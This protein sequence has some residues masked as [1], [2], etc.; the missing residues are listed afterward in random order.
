[1]KSEFSSPLHDDWPS[2]AGQRFVVGNSELSF[3]RT[4]I[5]WDA[6]GPGRG[7]GERYR[8]LQSVHRGTNLPTPL[9]ITSLVVRHV[10][11]VTK[12]T[13]TSLSLQ[14]LLQKQKVYFKQ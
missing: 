4:Y 12:T 11:S 1:M 13:Q 14:V 5:L 6:M 7:Y 2:N 10:E 9:L 3:P 8:R